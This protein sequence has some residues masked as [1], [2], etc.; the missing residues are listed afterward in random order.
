MPNHYRFPQQFDSWSKY[1][2]FKDFIAVLIL[3]ICSNLISKRWNF[4]KRRVDVVVS[5]FHG[6]NRLK[7]EVATELY[8][9]V[10]VIDELSSLQFDLMFEEAVRF[11]VSRNFLI[12]SESQ[13]VCGYTTKTF[14]ITQDGLSYLEEHPLA[15]V[16]SSK[17]QEYLGRR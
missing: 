14:Q 3:K 15:R 6:K 7:S 1:L 17:P 5:A 16:L 11:L 4:L 12:Q 9:N 8:N 13:S 2:G 10:S